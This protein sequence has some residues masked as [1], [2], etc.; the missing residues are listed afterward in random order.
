MSHKILKGFAAALLVTALAAPALAADGPTASLD[1]RVKFKD[2]ER[3]LRDLSTSLDIPRDKVCL[4]LSQYD[5]VNEAF[6]IVLGGV[7]AEYLG[8]NE[9]LAEQALTAP[10]AVDRVALHVCTTRVA[11]DLAEPAKA[12]LLKGAPAKGKPNAAW[13]RKTTQSVYGT[14]LSREPSKSETSQLASFYNTVAKDGGKANPNAVKDWVTLS[15]F[16]VASSL[17]NVFY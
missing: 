10:I 3:M 7:D 15:C 1:P 9:P 17:E 8:I 11:M 5:C 2:G 4:E 16:A 12:V 14:I 6:R 13:M